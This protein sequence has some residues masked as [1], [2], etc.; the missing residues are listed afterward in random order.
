[1]F[2]QIFSMV[3]TTE[4]NSCYKMRSAWN[5][6]QT[7]IPVMV[8]GWL[9][10][11]IFGD[12]DGE[13]QSRMFHPVEGVFT[14]DDDGSDDDG[15]K[16]DRRLITVGKFT[17]HIP[18]GVTW[19]YRS[20]TKMAGFLYG[21]DDEKGEFTG[22]DLTFIYPDFLTGLRGSFVMVCWRR[23]EQWMWLVRDARV[24]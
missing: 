13:V 8:N 12:G 11:V 7:S 17:E 1:M 23:L 9:Q 3:S 22:A 10:S 4:S 15:D 14:S 18:S 2:L 20:H 5:K 6:D 24:G 21:Q 16:D 19:Q